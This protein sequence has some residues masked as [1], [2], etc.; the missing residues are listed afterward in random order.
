MTVALITKSFRFAASHN[1]EWH[2]GK[3]QR[4]HGHTYTVDVEARGPIID[5]PGD[6]GHGMVVDFDVITAAWKEQLE[7]ILDHQHLNRSIPVYPTAE[8]IAAWLLAEF[9]TAIP[10]VVGVRVWESPMSSAYVSIDTGEQL[11]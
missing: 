9:R 11:A 4:L 8:N 10:E 5:A 2:A 7:P 1:L 3:C 6:S